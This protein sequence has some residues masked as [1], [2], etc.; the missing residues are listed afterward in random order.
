MKEWVDKILQLH[1]EME[2]LT[3]EA[4]VSAKQYE[5]LVRGIERKSQDI[6]WQYYEF[7]CNVYEREYA[8][9]HRIW[10]LPSMTEEVW[11]NY[12]TLF[13]DTPFEEV[14]LLREARKSLKEKYVAFWKNRPRRPRKKNTGGDH[15]N[16]TNGGVACDGNAR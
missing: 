11:E 10:T 14:T 13:R 4:G 8:E 7:F 9:V 1:K 15:Q 5:K 6:I 12:Y 16:V 2:K 3:L